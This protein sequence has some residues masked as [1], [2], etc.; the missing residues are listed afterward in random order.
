[1]IP[2][3]NNLLLT[4]IN[5]EDMPSKN[6]RMISESVRG[7]VDTERYVYPI[8]SWNYGIELVDLFGES[9]TYACPEITRRIE[10]ALLQDERINSVDQFE[11]DTSK[12]HE[13]VCTFSVHTIFGDFQME[14]EVSV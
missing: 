14:K 3:V 7:T 9:V 1:M 6:Y 2:S 5:E 8:Y 4:E 10:E 11:F 12:K 13:V